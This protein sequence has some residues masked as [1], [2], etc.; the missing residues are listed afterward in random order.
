MATVRQICADART[1]AGEMNFSDPSDT[2]VMRYADMALQKIG[3]LLKG[4]DQRIYGEVAVLNLSTAAGSAVYAD[5][6]DCA[7]THANKTITDTGAFSDADMTN[8]GIVVGTVNGHNFFAYVVSKTDNTIVLDRDINDGANDDVAC[9]YIYI[10]G[11]TT[12]NPT[13]TLPADFVDEIIMVTGSRA[14]NL[15]SLDVDEFLTVAN[16]VN[17]A[18]SGAFY[19]NGTSLST[20]E[21]SSLSAGLGTVFVFFRRR[22]RRVTAMTETVDLPIKYHQ[23]LRDE[24][25]KVLMIRAGKVPHAEIKDPLAPLK[26][27]YAVNQKSIEAAQKKQHVPNR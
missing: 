16:N 22:P 7:Y 5:S 18:S 1:I 2:E 17:Y 6:G 25:A 21:G 24:L 19:H 15:V 3:K 4:V 27:M 13:L 26:A 8:R 12:A 10:S 9:A 11:V 23:L 20:Y 14:G